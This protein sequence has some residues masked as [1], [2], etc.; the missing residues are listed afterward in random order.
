MS[1]RA[2]AR[3]DPPDSS[4]GLRLNAKSHHCSLMR[5]GPD[6]PLIL[7]R[8]GPWTI[9]IADPRPDPFA[10]GARYVHGGYI[11]G[12]LRDGRRLTGRAGLG[13][14]SVDGEGAPDS[15]ELDLAFAHAEP[16]DSFMRIGAG[17]VV[18][19]GGPRRFYS[20]LD[21]GLTWEVVEHSEAH[22]VMRTRDLIWRR[23][24]EFAYELTR[25]VRVRD[26]GLDSTTTLALRTPWNHPL[27]WFPHAFWAHTA[28]DATGYALPAAA[29]PTGN[30]IQD[31]QGLWRL[32][33]SGGEQGIAVVTGLWGHCGSID[34]QL[35]AA[36]GGGAVRMTLDRPWDHV[37]LWASRR[38]TSA[39]PL[40][41]RIWPRNDTASWTIGYTWL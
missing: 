10:L 13:W 18:R 4:H 17:R 19:D 26:D 38:A 30:V 12:I 36:L 5:T 2:W 41:S 6:L 32:R 21:L 27:S 7:L 33:P 34:C 14:N 22:L 39:E 3:S 24:Q 25:A 15:F 11:H 23:G 29:T 20:Q 31:A 35:D 1:W 16:G 40:L 28:L 9:E 8:Q 37:V